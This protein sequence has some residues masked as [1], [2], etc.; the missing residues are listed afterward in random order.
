MRGFLIAMAAAAAPAAPALLA[1]QTCEPPHSSNESKLMAHYMVPIAFDAGV[2]PNVMPTGSIGLSI[3]GAYI[4][5]LD[6]AA[7][8]PTTCKPGQGPLNTNLQT[9]L[10]RPRLLLSASGGFFLELAWIPPIPVNGVQSNV[11]SIAGG[12]NVV[13][14][15]KTIMR[16]RGFYTFGSIKGPFTCSTADT[17]DPNNTTCFG[18]QESND[19]FHPKELSFDLSVAYAMGNRKLLP[20]FSAGIGFPH[21]RFNVNYTDSLGITDQT[22]IKDN[23]TAF[24]V[25]GGLSWLPSPKFQMSAEAYSAVGQG[26]T[27][28]ALI[29]YLIKS[30]QPGKKSRR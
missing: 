26:W 25:A 14:G 18:G 20:Y 7:R 29:T 16:V 30:G 1:A 28:R 2:A 22:E 8:T 27:A 17:Q 5:P 12:R 19:S 11:F 13:S 21:P 15:K 9:W 23:L 3:E 10:V 6:S 24:T 4:P